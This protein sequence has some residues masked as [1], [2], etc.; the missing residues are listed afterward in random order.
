MPDRP[1]AVRA[2]AGPV[3]V[4]VAAAAL[5]ALWPSLVSLHEVWREIH[6]YQHGYLIAA[7]SAAWCGLA[8]RRLWTRSV[9]PSLAGGILLAVVLF[10]WLVALNANSLMLHQLL[11]PAA[12]WL[13]VLAATGWSAARRV[14]VP[15]A[16]LY[17]ATPIWEYAL[18][19]L[20][21]LSVFAAETALGALGIP[22]EVREYTV[23][24]PEGT[25][26][27]IEGCSG[28]RYVM[29]V[30]AVAVLAASL[31][32]LP[33]RRFVG[34]IAASG[35][36]AL[37]ANWVRIAIVIYAGHVSGMQH[38]FVAVEHKT[39]GN[40]IFVVLVV[41][42]LMLARALSPVPAS[43]P[44]PRD[45]DD[46]AAGTS[47]PQPP[48]AGLIALPLGL[49]LATLALTQVRAHAAPAVARPG[50]LPI[51]TGTWQGP[52][53]ALERWAPAY[54]Q[55]DGERRA[56]YSS[57]AGS[58]EVYLNAY[59]EQRQGRE[60]VYFGNT[61]MAPGTWSR[62]WPQVTRLLHTRTPRLRSFE[63]HSG[64]GSLWLI[65]YTFEVGG[66]T[67]TSEPWAQLVYGLQSLLRP[68]PGGV[69]ALAVQCDENC[70]AARALVTSFWD[71]M[72]ALV[73][74]AVPDE[75]RDP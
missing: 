28:K 74:A 11:F 55:P 22:V 2:H 57:A 51:A 30:L 7:V 47:Q 21:R 63:A 3:A 39:L 17:F 40:A 25:F 18:P 24:I 4:V 49:L 64:D 27:I 37:L 33:P 48:H 1:A 23:T 34:F 26:Q 43:R 46:G 68:S 56:A 45:G 8:A 71:D 31:A 13:A 61:L 12:A 66:W 35:A 20:Q 72:H 44:R 32:R 36:L 70:E 9:R 60:L 29:V 6:D 15:I 69:V 73:L 52:L 10:A 41:G 5:I 58:V 54:V 75:G 62:A 50:S 65:A 53:P 42:V 38:Y 14:L 16:F 59:G 67:T 19:V